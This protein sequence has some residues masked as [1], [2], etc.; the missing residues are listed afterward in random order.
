M[1]VY[2]LA[3]AYMQPAECVHQAWAVTAPV[4]TPRDATLL[5]TFWVHVAR[6]LQP[7][8]KIS[9]TAEDG[10]WYQELLCLVADGADVRMKELGFWEL[11]DTSDVSDTSDTM[12]VEWAGP[13]HKFRVV[14][15][16]DGVVLE[17]GFKT[18]VDASR[19]MVNNSRVAA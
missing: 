16:S 10:S 19:W 5:A 3:E 12:L 18:R 4:G 11:E 13:Y 7:L 15:N 8:A 2:K 1:S 14:R 17:K 6:K 9:V